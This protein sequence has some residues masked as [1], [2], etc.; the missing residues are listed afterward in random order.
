MVRH[1][2]S[3]TVTHSGMGIFQAPVFFCR[4]TLFD[5]LWGAELF[6]DFYCYNGKNPA[7]SFRISPAA[8]TYCYSSK[9]ALFA[10]PLLQKK[11]ETR[12]KMP[13]GEKKPPRKKATQEINPLE[14]RTA[15]EIT[16]QGKNQSKIPA[17][18]GKNHSEKRLPGEKPFSI[19]TLPAPRAKWLTPSLQPEMKR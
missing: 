2:P 14:K 18:R 19:H 6:A 10:Q 4:V 9:K 11:K 13:T 3:D 12:E 8:K 1:F 5:G 16:P 15:R 17:T 7:G